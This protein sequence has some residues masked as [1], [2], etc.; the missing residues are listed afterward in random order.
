MKIAQT[1]PAKKENHKLIVKVKIVVV[2]SC[3]HSID[4]K[5][6]ANMQQFL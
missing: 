4:A 6:A 2:Q 1:R 5:G 3:I